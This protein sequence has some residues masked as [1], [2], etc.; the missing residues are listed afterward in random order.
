VAAVFVSAAR[1]RDRERRDHG[2]GIK[3]TTG[4]AHPFDVRGALRFSLP[5]L[6]RFEPDSFNNNL[7]RDQSIP[8]H[9]ERLL[10][11]PVNNGNE[12]HVIMDGNDSKAN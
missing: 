2:V 3:T 6:R 1:K 10:P 4:E 11:S 7:T 8:D 12:E 9:G 5:P